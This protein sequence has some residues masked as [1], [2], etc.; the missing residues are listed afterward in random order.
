M[1]CKYVWNVSRP[2]FD[3]SD[4]KLIDGNE[5]VTAHKT[6][7]CMTCKHSDMIAKCPPWRPFVSPNI[8]AADIWW[9]C[10][11]KTL[12]PSLPKVWTGRCVRVKLIQ[13]TTLYPGTFE[14]EIVTSP[15]HK[16]ELLSDNSQVYIDSIGV[17]RGVPN[18]Y[19]ARDQIA[20]GFTAALPFFGPII[21][22]SKNTEWI[23]YNYY[24]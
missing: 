21:E 3:Y 13:Q 12:L 19:K 9:L 10:G 20:G 15:R 23:N 6:K 2:I 18:E 22:A 16:R 24:C 17:P 1:S 11:H 4:F 8:K 14:T 5:I 7:D